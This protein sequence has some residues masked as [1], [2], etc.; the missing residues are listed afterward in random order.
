MIKIRK[1]ALRDGRVVWR[2]RGLS[3]GK[4]PVTGKRAQ[5]TITAPTKREVEAELS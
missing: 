3:T 2:A 4:N 5:R 1:E